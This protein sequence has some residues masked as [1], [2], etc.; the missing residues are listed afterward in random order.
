ME[1]T[2]FRKTIFVFAYFSAF[3]LLGGCS[4][5]PDYSKVPKTIPIARQ[6]H[7][8][9]RIQSGDVLDIKFPFTEKHNEQV[10]VRPDGNILIQIAGE[11][12]AAGRTP[13]ELSDNLERL[14]S[15]RLKNPEVIVMVTQSSQKIFVGGEVESEGTVSFRDDLTPLQAITER[16]GFKDTADSSKVFVIKIKNDTA[17]ITEINLAQ[18]SSTQLSANDVV[19]IPKTG[20]AKANLAV[21]QYIRNMMPS[22]WIRFW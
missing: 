15:R 16:G 19:F 14:T 21:Q 8:D 9:Y 20:V 22:Q 13:V 17:R 1:K 12:K 18:I 10:L 4:S 6:D 7:V 11:V 3:L 5:M 2:I